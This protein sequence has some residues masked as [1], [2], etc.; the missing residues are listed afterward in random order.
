MEEEEKKKSKKKKEEE[1]DRVQLSAEK[2]RRTEKAS[3]S[4][5]FSD[6]NFPRMWIFF[7]VWG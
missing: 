3:A 7:Q 5:N 4:S 6:S 1:E 2:P